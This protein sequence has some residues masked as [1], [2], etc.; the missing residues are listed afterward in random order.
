MKIFIS[1][2]RADTKYRYEI[3]EILKT[4][5]INYFAVPEDADFNGKSNEIIRR[6]TC[7]KV[8]QCDVLICLVGRETYSR[9]H[10]D[11]E[12]HEAL[13]GDVGSRLGIIAIFLPTRKDSLK[14]AEFNTISQKLIDNKDYVVWEYWSNLNEK[15]EKLIQE[16]YNNSFN[17]KIQTKHTNQCLPLK[18]KVYYDN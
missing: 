16:A 7:N 6:Y 1:Y 11:R 15:I 14:N 13:K 4:H 8:K 12:I 10:V 17:K 18:S 3:E 2:H 9:P 5:K